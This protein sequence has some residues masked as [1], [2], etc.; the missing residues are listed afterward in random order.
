[1]TVIRASGAGNDPR[2]DSARACPGREGASTRALVIGLALVEDRLRSLGSR[3]TQTGPTPCG[4]ALAAQLEAHE[5]A[6]LQTSRRR[7]LS[8]RALATDGE[9]PRGESAGTRPTW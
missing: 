4:T 5:R 2:D 6:S 1:M 3:R 8:F 7:R 9:M